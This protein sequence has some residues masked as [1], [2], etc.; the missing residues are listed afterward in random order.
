MKYLLDILATHGVPRPS[1]GWAGGGP[2]SLS[3]YGASGSDSLRVWRIPI[4]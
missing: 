2:V 4:R 1:I 3:S